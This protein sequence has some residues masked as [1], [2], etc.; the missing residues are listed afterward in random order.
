[1]R[2]KASLFVAAWDLLNEA[3]LE[4][5]EHFGIIKINR[6]IKISSQQVQREIS[7]LNEIF[8]RQQEEIGFSK[9]NIYKSHS[10]GDIGKMGGFS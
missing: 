3:G 1:M 2:T 8:C 10:F 5:T 4:F 9:F 7:T 6:I